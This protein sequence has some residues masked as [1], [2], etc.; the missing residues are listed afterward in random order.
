[1][2]DEYENLTWR[3]S[4]R[5][6]TEEGRKIVDGVSISVSLYLSQIRFRWSRWLVALTH[7]RRIKDYWEADATA[8]LRGRWRR[9]ERARV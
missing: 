1:M 6:N 8:A 9:E 2:K 4:S 7:L 5:E 3:K